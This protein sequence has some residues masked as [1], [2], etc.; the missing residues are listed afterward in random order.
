M[1]NDRSL[2][3]N[4]E[5]AFV[6]DSRKSVNSNRLNSQ[7][8]DKVFDSDDRTDH[9]EVTVEVGDDDEDDDED[10]DYERSLRE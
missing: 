6:R 2:S 4:Y 7:T 9:H 8:N 3:W 10:N 1:S 5:R